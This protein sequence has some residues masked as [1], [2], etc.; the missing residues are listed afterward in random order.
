[1]ADIYNDLSFMVIDLLKPSSLGGFGQLPIV[2]RRSTPGVKDPAQPTKRVEPVVVQEPLQAAM[3]IS[4][5]RQ[6][7][8]A[9]VAGTGKVVAVPPSTVDYTLDDGG[10]VTLEIIANNRAYHV[11]KVE[12]KPPVGK[13]VAVVFTVSV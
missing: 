9:N 8:N 3:Q 12:V 13:A 6:N 11:T 1:M 10:D 5:E 2:L 7:G 4:Q